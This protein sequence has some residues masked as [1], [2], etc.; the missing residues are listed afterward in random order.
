MARFNNLDDD[1]S[2][3]QKF[4]MNDENAHNESKIKRKIIVKLD[5][6]REIKRKCKS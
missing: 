4:K 3:Y 5:K 6:S 1:F 2:Q